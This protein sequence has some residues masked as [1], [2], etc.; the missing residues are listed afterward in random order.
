[1]E[2]PKWN[3]WPNRYL[4][5]LFFC[6]ARL[7]APWVQAWHLTFFL[8]S[9][10]STGLGTNPSNACA[11][12]SALS[13]RHRR[14]SGLDPQAFRRPMKMFFFFFKSERRWTEHNKNN[15]YIVMNPGSYLSLYPHNSEMQLLISF[16]SFCGQSGPGWQECLGPMTGILQPWLSGQHHLLTM[17]L[18]LLGLSGA[19]LAAL[20]LSL[21]IYA[22]KNSSESCVFCPVLPPFKTLGQ[23]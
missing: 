21:F 19:A 20:L 12:W 5:P 18:K 8:T 10:L 9:W 16:R 22:W 7:D 1:M 14:H 17:K 11:C 13:I 15:E 4:L 23:K 6:P 2:N 3:F